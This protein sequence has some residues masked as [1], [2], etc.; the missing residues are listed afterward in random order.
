MTAPP[1]DLTF[2]TAASFLTNTN[3]Q[4]YAGETTVSYFTQMAGLAVQ[5]FISAGVGIAV[6]VAFVRALAS[7]SGR[8]SASSTST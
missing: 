8:G 5:N 2:N 7:R 3:W 6:V 1:W 4:Y